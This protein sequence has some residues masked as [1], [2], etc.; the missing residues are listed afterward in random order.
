MNSFYTY[1]LIIFFIFILINIFFKKKNHEKFNNHKPKKEEKN[2]DNIINVYIIHMNGNKNRE[3]SIEEQKKKMIGPFNIQIFPAVNGKEL[4][5][6]ELKKNEGENDNDWLVPLVKRRG[7]VGCYLS[8]RNIMD[9]IRKVKDSS[10]YSIIFEDDF[11]VNTNDLYSSVYKIINTLNQEK[12]DFD[13]IYLGNLNHNHAE[14]IKDN[15]YEL[16][17]KQDLWGT[18][19]YLIK[20]ESADKIYTLIKK[21]VKPIDNIYQDL[22]YQDKLKGYVIFPTIINQ[23]GESIINGKK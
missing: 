8:H 11:K 21:I 6:K 18:H 17:K 13:M 10:K 14:K 15:I 5:F 19:G 12:K 16:N 9:K 1:L 4:D 22:L 3:N 23:E 2:N 7:E 20:N